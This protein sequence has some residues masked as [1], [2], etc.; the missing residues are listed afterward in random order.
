VGAGEEVTTVAFA[1]ARAAV[2]REAY[3]HGL[4]LMEVFDAANECSSCGRL[5]FD[6]ERTDCAPIVKVAP[7]PKYTFPPMPLALPAPKPVLA[8]AAPDLMT[9]LKTAKEAAVQTTEA[10][11]GYKSDGVTPRKRP[12]PPAAS[13]EKA[14][15]AKAAKRTAV[16]APADAYQERARYLQ[17]EAQSRATA[18]V[19]DVVRKVVLDLDA[20]IARLRRA[21]EA[22]LEAVAA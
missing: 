3:S 5:Y 10:P 4:D 12:A 19:P 20:E 17:R 2:V 14:R 8:L 22:V 21:R 15:A 11:F 13:L 1:E 16:A 7:K 6:C 18:H 9:T